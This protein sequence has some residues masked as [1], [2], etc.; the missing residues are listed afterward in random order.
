MDEIKKKELKSAYW[1]LGV[2][3]IY[4]Y[5]YRING[6][7]IYIYVYYIGC[8]H[9]STPICIYIYIYTRKA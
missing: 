8:I 9:L 5:T 1:H 3:Y 2:T 4:I 7:Y 6:Y